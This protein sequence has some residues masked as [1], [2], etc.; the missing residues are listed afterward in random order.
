MK[1]AYDFTD[2]LLLFYFFAA[3]LGSVVF[4]RGSKQKYFFGALYKN[5]DDEVDFISFASVLEGGWISC[6]DCRLPLWLL[7]GGGSGITAAAL[8]F[9]RCVIR[10]RRRRRV[11]FVVVLT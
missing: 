7:R 8:Y 2:C 10:P 1:S 3:F 9:L 5:S 11:F 4:S 6:G